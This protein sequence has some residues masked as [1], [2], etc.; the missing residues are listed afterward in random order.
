MTKAI[1]P[2]WLQTVQS[3]GRNTTGWQFI[4]YP[5]RRMVIVNVPDPA[6][7]TY[8]FVMNAEALTWTLF[9]GM[10]ATSWAVLEGNLFFGT[11]S[12]GVWQADIGSSDGTA[13]IDCLSVGA[14]QRMGDGLA[15]KSTTLIGVDCIIDSNVSLYAGSSFNYRT[16]TPSALGVSQVGVPA[17]LWDMAIWDQAQWSGISP[18]RL[19]ADA[20][21]CGVVFAPTVRALIKG[22]ASVPSNCQI[23]GGTMHVQMGSGI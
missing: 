14:W 3:V 15:E 17:A 9:S 18:Q 21:G 20:G 12:S 13:P 22:N 5:G 1:A 4:T 10:P 19:I 8:Q 2:T 23:L 7:G 11:A 6:V 16:T